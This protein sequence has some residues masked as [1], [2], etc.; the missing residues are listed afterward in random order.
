MKYH[1]ASIHREAHLA[2]PHSIPEI[3]KYPPKMIYASYRPQQGQSIE[4]A[5]QALNAH[6]HHWLISNIDNDYFLIAVDDIHHL[7]PVISGEDFYIPFCAL[8]KTHI[9]FHK[10]STRT[11]NAHLFYYGQT[12]EQCAVDHHGY[13]AI[14]SQ[15]SFWSNR[16]YEDDWK[17]LICKEHIKTLAGMENE[18]SIF[19]RTVSPEKLKLLTKPIY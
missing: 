8:V 6:I 18:R 3:E 16:V 1:Y 17:H 13:F 10:Y 14:N 9:D 11:I 7:D 19:Y 12:P 2:H 4:D 5:T 15:D